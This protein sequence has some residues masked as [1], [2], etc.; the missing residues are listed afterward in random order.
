MMTLDIL[1][2]RTCL[3][4]TRNHLQYHKK[5]K[6]KEKEK[7]RKRKEKEKERK[8][9]EKKRRK[10]KVMSLFLEQSNPCRP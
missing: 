3:V 8:K 2:Q 6:E 1:K 5:K 4:G 10:E 7:K 9:E